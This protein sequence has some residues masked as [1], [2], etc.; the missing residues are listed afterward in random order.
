MRWKVVTLAWVLGAGAAQAAGGRVG[1]RPVADQAAACAALRETAEAACKT[2]DTVTTSFG[3]VSLIES[4]GKSWRWAIVLT[5]GDRLWMSAPVEIALSA[6][7]DVPRSKRAGL[8][9]LRRG[10]A[11]DVGAEIVLVLDHHQ[12][13]EEPLPVLDEN[14]SGGN[15]HHRRPEIVSVD[16]TTPWTRSAFIVCAPGAGGPPGCVQRAF[17]AWKKSC[18][19]TMDD[20]GVVDYSCGADQDLAWKK[21]D[22][23]AYLAGSRL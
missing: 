22:L 12:I 20:H 23:P 19:A 21:A 6:G 4:A 1:M 2:V 14:M 17:G 16:R 3:E 18:R 5:A 13:V 7:H 10:D 8:R 9:A 11:E 15:R